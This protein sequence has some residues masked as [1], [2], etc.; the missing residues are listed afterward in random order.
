MTLWSRLKT[1]F[2]MKLVGAPWCTACADTSCIVLTS[3][4]IY[5]FCPILRTSQ[6]LQCSL[7]LYPVVVVFLR[8]HF[9]IGLHVVMPEAA[10]LGAHNFIL[11]NFRSGEMN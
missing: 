1:C 5:V 2:R 7:L 4:V 8:H 9:Q 6:L 10:K 11:A 3:N